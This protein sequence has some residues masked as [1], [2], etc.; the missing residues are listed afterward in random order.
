MSSSHARNI[1]VAIFDISSSSVG[2]A[3]ALITKAANTEIPLVEKVAILAQARSEAPLQ[4]ELNIERFV[5]EALKGLETVATAV[6][7]ADVH[8]PNIFR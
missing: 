3:H 1:P 7:K 4:T 8:H 6:R 2:G 5:A